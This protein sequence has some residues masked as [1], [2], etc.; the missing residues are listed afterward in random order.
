M[1]YGE[2]REPVTILLEPLAGIEDGFML[3]HGSDDVIAPAAMSFGD[4][5][6]RQVVAFS[7]ARSEYDFVVLRANQGCDL[8]P[9]GLNR[10]VGNP[11]KGVATAGGI[12][13]CV[14]EV[15]KHLIEHT[16]INGCG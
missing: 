13:E 15:R 8:C 7:G 14:R 3:G 6:D 9:R 16:R 2:I 4:A 11:S 12:A 10:L 5:F 1:L